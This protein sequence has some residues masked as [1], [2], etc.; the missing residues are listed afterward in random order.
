M[1]GDQVGPTNIR[2]IHYT[3][4]E[5]SYKLQWHFDVNQLTTKCCV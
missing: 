2:V 4:Y 3:L 1:K 5:K